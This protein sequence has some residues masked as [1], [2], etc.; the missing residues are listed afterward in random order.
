MAANGS[1]DDKTRSFTALTAGVVV[2]HYEIISRIGAGGMGEVYL[3]EDTELKRK[4]ALKFLSPHL[5]QDEDCQ[6]R[7]KREARAAAALKHANIITIHEV[8]EFDGR[9][10]MVMEYIEGRS[11]RDIIKEKKLSINDVIN[12]TMQ[13]CA[14]LN[15]AHK[16]GIVHR[17]IKPSNILLDKNNQ[18]II[19]DFGLATIK[20]GEKITKTGST[21]GTIGY[22][23][24]EQIKGGKTDHR[25][26]LFSLGVVI[27]EII[28]GRQPFYHE[29]EA[30]TTNAILN[31]DPEPIARFKSGTTSEMQRIMDKILS[32][33]ASTRYQT[34]ADIAA[35]LKRLSSVVAPQKKSKMVWYVTAAAVLAALIGYFAVDNFMSH[36][37]TGNEDWINSVAVLVFRDLSPE[38]DQEWFCEGM[39][40]EII[41][42]LSSIPQLKVTSMQSMLRFKGTD[43]DL[44]V[45]G[46]EL[47]VTNILEGNIQKS[48]DRIRVR[49][50]LIRTEDN[51]HIWSE[52]Y[53]QDI[54]DVFKIQDEISYAISE[55][56]ETTL[57]GGKEIFA[58]RRGTE[59]LEAYNN[60]LQGRYFWRKRTQDGIKK[61][62]E[63][64]QRAVDV[65]P[66]FA[67]AW[68]GLSDAYAFQF[69]ITFKYRP[70]AIPNAIRAARKAVELD[71]ILAETHAS[72]GLALY[73]DGNIAAALEE[74]KI[75]LDINPQY[76]WTHI[77]YGD[78][79]A[80]HM[81][82]KDVKIEHLKKA[83]VL[84]PLNIDALSNLA[85][86]LSDSGL[87]AEAETHYLKVIEIVPENVLYRINLAESYKQAGQ[88]EKMV[89]TYENAIEISPFHWRLYQ[90]YANAEFGLG[91]E[92]EAR[93]VFEN[94]IKA[95]PDSVNSYHLYGNWLYHTPRD[96]EQSVINLKKA[97]ELNP[98]C[99]ESYNVMAYA[100]RGIDDFDRAIESVNK[101]IEI[102]PEYYGYVDTRAD[103]YRYFGYFEDAIKD[104]K[105]FLDKQPHDMS[106]LTELAQAAIFSRKYNL[107]D[108]AYQAIADQVSLERRGWGQFMLSRSLRHQGRFRESVNMMTTGIDIVRTDVGVSKQ[109]AG[110][111]WIRSQ[112]YLDW[113]LEYDKALEDLDS[114]ESITMVFP[115]DHEYDIAME[116]FQ[117][118][119][120]M[121]YATMGD[122]ERVK[123]WWSQVDSSEMKSYDYNA[124]H[125][126]L[127]L[128]NPTVAA[129]YFER[130]VS[131]PATK[132]TRNKGWL[133][134]AYLL[135]GK[136]EKAVDILEQS[137]F[138]HD[139]VKAIYP[140]YA[141]R[142]RYYL[143]RAYEAVGR[144][145]DAID[146]YETFLDIW[147]NA[148]EGLESVEDARVRLAKLK[149]QL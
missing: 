97:I 116:S 74:Y 68:S 23:S 118:Q 15:E 31:E 19:L 141:V 129:G 87:Y 62:L 39:T 146:Q 36:K 7:F 13:I 40:D 148:D 58:S 72:L 86:V 120:Q 109:L 132:S 133:G 70:E 94:L 78:A 127:R 50:Q 9:P 107:A 61:A 24:P 43:L 26:D 142:N 38:G 4:V 111:Y 71:S 49:A 96:Y 82:R 16:A 30:A 95:L 34:A 130:V 60:Y 66:N 138:R 122:T 73:K 145:N 126:H 53:E 108:S 124:G 48:G 147:K 47:G 65:D 75:A 143:A 10:F 121:V 46:K 64:F 136:Y 5:C 137:V 52:R 1:D 85:D 44:K 80:S 18:P 84:D 113:L 69:D 32:K 55:V 93:G 41:G 98:Q 125:I 100:Y 14:G 63:Y 22:M 57:L 76:V 89:E 28:T 27:Y 21:L 115:K 12:L 20:G 112:M 56:L 17:D 90:N 42:R 35:D 102:A 51:A 117:V 131:K 134:L 139:G 11:L 54:M 33:D 144:T 67:L 114:A 45:I 88:Y 103:I 119:K 6:A 83:V 149:G 128:G 81:R 2:T 59:N 104:Y 110:L 140:A 123:L 77:W 135:G 101:A 8:S 92:A 25:S 91:H 105:F 3:A 37:M 79:M 106:T 99:D 29:S